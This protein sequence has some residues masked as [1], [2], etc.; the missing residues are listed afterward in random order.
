MIK[1]DSVDEIIKFVWDNSKDQSFGGG[2]KISGWDMELL[3]NFIAFHLLNKSLY[4]VSENGKTVA[5]MTAWK[6]KRSKLGA[7][8]DWSSDDDGDCIFVSDITCSDKKALRILALEMINLCGDKP[9]YAFRDGNLV[10]IT[11]RYLNF[12]IK[13]YG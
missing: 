4:A 5:V 9:I 11:K 3:K 8:F 13:N 7:P 6:T 1:P 2:G 10:E 12:I